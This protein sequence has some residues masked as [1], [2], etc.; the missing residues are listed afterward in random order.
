MIGIVVPQE[1]DGP[2]PNGNAINLGEL[3]LNME[4]LEMNYVLVK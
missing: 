2:K 3:A 1:L 4:G